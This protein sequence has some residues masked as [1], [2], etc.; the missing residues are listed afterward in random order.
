MR[1]D[2]TAVLDLLDQRRA[3]LPDPA[4]AEAKRLLARRD[5]LL[6]R[7]GALAASASGGVKIRV[8]G[9]YHL[10]QVLVVQNDFVIADFEGEPGRSLAER[11]EKRTAMKDVAGMLRSFDYAMHAA[12]LQVGPVATETRAQLVGVGRQ[13]QCRDAD[14]V[15]GWLRPGRADDRARITARRR[16]RAARADAV[17]KGRLR[18]QIR[19]RQPPGLGTHPAGRLVRHSGR[20][21]P[22]TGVIPRAG[23]APV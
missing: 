5:E 1:S 4:R 3:S 12:L 7:I 16:S 23:R 13:W 14:D 20:R 2:A 17:G 8:H 10:A 22:T 19:A 15:P 6:A 18:A 9:D 21:N 11:A